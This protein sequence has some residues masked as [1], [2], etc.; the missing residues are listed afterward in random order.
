MSATSSSVKRA[1]AVSVDSDITVVSTRPHA[2]LLQAVR[3]TLDGA[4]E[5]ILALPSWKPGSS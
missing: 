3:H 5:A 2:G 1:E 4:D